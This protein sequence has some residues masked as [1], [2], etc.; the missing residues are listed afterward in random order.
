MINL[1]LDLMIC[2]TFSQASVMTSLKHYAKR[3][4]R[5]VVGASVVIYEVFNK[6][7]AN[8]S[9]GRIEYE[10]VYGLRGAKHRVDCSVHIR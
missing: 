7:L 2:H 8:I 6:H 1:E 9:E 4:Y 5:T 10:L 3:M